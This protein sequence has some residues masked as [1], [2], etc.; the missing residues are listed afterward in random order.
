MQTSTVMILQ[1]QC[2]CL[3]QAQAPVEGT[4]DTKKS[5]WRTDVAPVVAIRRR[6]AIQCYR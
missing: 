4:G 5:G 1:L 2:W 6:F 3:L